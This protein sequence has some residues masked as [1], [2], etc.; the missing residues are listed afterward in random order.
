MAFDF[1]HIWASMGALG[2]A[3]AAVLLIMA[4]A[5]AGVTVERLIV[6][7]KSQRES[8]KFA[9]GAGPLINSWDLEQLLV[10]CDKHKA[11]ALAKLFGSILRRYTTAKDGNV[12]PVEMARGESERSLEAAGNDLRRGLS[13]LASVG[14]V[15]PFV[16][17]L[18]TVIGIIGAFQGI[19]STGSGGLGAVSA[20]I[21]EALIETAFGLMVAI[22]AVL[23]FNWLTTRINNIELTLSRSA[24]ELLD[25]IE[26]NHGRAV[27]SVTTKK[28]A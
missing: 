11:S 20:G 2:K 26:N 3:I 13:V 14:S 1:A 6:L 4:I 24:G 21:A 15:A 19:A 28:A 18:G 9:G 17:L 22:P 7:S 25:E 10:L 16:G 12:S 27:T 8:R 23:V 5:C